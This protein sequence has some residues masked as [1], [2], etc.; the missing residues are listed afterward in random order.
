MKIV[1]LESGLVVVEQN[2]RL[3]IYE[4]GYS[5]SMEMSCIY[6]WM[7]KHLDEFANKDEL[8]NAIEE[9]NLFG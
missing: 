3:A 1:L 6:V 4:D 7:D 2:N 5:T 8:Q 9:L